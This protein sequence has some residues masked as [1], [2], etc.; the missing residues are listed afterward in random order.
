M[1]DTT[2]TSIT[3]FAYT[4]DKYGKFTYANRPLT[5]LLGIEPDEIV[6]KSFF[7]LPYE[8]ELAQKLSD[9]ILEVF[10]TGHTVRDQTRFIDPSGQMGFYEYIF[11]PVFNSDGIVD[12]VAGSTRNVTERVQAETALRESEERIRIAV[13]AAGL[14]TWEWDLTDDMVFWTDRSSSVLG[15]TT[16]DN[17][18]TASEFFKVLDVRDVDILRSRLTSAAGAGETLDA[19]FRTQRLDGTFRWISAYGKVTRWEN[20]TATRL[21]GVAADI[22]VRKQAEQ[23]V[24]ESQ[25]KL[26][27]VFNGTSE[28]IGLL[29]VDGTLLEA[30]RALLEFGPAK[31]EDA[32]GRPFWEIFWFS[33]T[34]EMVEVIRQGVADA[35]RGKYFNIDALI[36]SASGNAHFFRITFSPI[37]DADGNVIFILPMGTDITDQMAA[38]DAIGRQAALIEL[39]QEPIFVWDLNDGIVEWNQGAE[40][41]YGYSRSEAI[42]QISN[43]LLRTDYPDVLTDFLERLRQQGQWFGEVTQ[44][45]KEG[46][47]L[48]IET[49]QQLL[50]SGGKLLVLETNRDITERRFASELLQRYRMLSERSRDAIWFLDSNGRFMDVN[51]AAIENYGYTRDEFL[52]MSIADVRHPSTSVELQRQI[53]EANT[54]GISFESVHVRKDGTTFPVDVTANAADLDGKRMVMAIVRDISERKAVEIALIESEE[55]SHLAQ[56]AGRV[57]VWDWDA[58]TGKTYWSRSMFLFYGEEPSDINPDEKYWIDHLHPADR[59][60]L[61]LNLKQTRESDT[62][63]FHDEFRII[64]KDGSVGWIESTAKVVRDVTGEAVRMYGVNIEITERKDAQERVRLS[65]NQLRLVTNAVP[66]LISYVDNS[67]RLRFANAKFTEWFGLPPEK[68]VG[69]RVRDVFGQDAYRIL[70]PRVAEALAGEKCTFETIL[71]YKRAGER[72]V[73]ISYMPDI[74]VDGTVHGYYAMT[75]DLTDLKRSQDLLRSS[76]ERL[77]LMMEDLTDYAIFSMDR[78]GAIDSWNMG[79]ELIFGYSREEVMGLGC[80]VLFTPE[81]VD[82]GIH[83]REMASARETGRAS[84]DRWHLRKGGT[85]FFASGVMIPVFVGKTLT[86]Y[87][88]IASDLTERKRRAEELQRAHDELEVRVEERTRELADANLALL[89]EMEVREVAERQRADLLARLVTSQEFERRRIARDLHDQLGQ[90]LTALR[91][92]IESLHEISAQYEPIATRVRRLQEIAEKLDSEVS[93]LA[94]ELRPTALDDLGLVDA[95]G[96]FVSEWSRH[97]EIEA[98][99]HANGLGNVR[100]D[101]EIETHL[102]RITQEALNNIVK[103]A[104]ANTVTVILEKRES[105]VILIIEDNGK[106]FDPS[107]ENITAGSSSGLGLVGM[108]ERGMLVNGEVEIESAAGKGTTIFVR[109][110]EK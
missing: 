62:E 9:Q 101:H 81:D 4:F 91:L 66:A 83:L 49:R 96:A 44:V 30:N 61:I 78:N 108:R 59:E 23:E 67:E 89:G 53:H 5:D 84:D 105:N 14:V 71:S 51:Q 6:G 65:E 22:T 76:E 18:T 37:K 64:R 42:G 92:K 10:D 98:E 63:Q 102:Y 11:N 55:R 87:A 48:K 69:K 1:F 86:G 31:R 2:L 27:A 50:E 56:E 29:S 20:G 72:Y 39:S 88:K 82:E 3:D 21:S 80:E 19:E 25:Q 52:S 43:E 36:N 60:R 46:R 68:I 12:A 8:P 90:Q 103:H 57:G 26:S 77:G 85:R 70:K 34:P 7:E 93:F 109:V 110:P 73:N 47:T 35:S 24:R 40:L 17:P 32:I 106:G 33:H 94:W 75:H 104:D 28:F 99:F 16:L 97:Y 58:S 54:D 41:L 100:L 74:G 107:D 45:S 79:A 95:V 15:K 13:D 38:A